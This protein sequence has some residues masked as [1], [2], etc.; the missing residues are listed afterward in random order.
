MKF[1]FAK[2]SVAAGALAAVLAL[3][4]CTMH[5]APKEQASLYD[6]LGGKPAIE[7]VVGQF[8][9][10]VVADDRINGFFANVDAADLQTKLVDQICEASGGPCAYTGRDMATTHKGLG[11]TDDHFNALVED[12]VAALDQFNVPEREKNELL[13]ALGPMK[14]DIVDS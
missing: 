12:L 4:A 9:Q 6:R 11:I 3:G 14:G 8:L 7:A 13:G 5:D 10:N 1:A 2:K